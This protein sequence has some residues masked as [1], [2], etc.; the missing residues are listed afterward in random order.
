MKC[1]WPTAASAALGGWLLIAGARATAGEL[2]IEFNPQAK[3]YQNLSP[4]LRRDW[5]EERGDWGRGF[6]WV[7][8]GVG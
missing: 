6:S 5:I 4:Q 2:A 7:V 1:R 8:T 3:D